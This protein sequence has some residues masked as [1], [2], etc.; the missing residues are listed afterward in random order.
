MSS[1]GPLS[2]P[3]RTFPA[4]EL[5]PYA[6]PVRPDEMKDHRVYFA[7]QYSG[8]SGLVPMLRPLLFV[9]YLDPDDPNLRFF[10]DYDS[11]VAGVRHGSADATD[12]EHAFEVCGPDGGKYIF[13]Y[14]DALHE[15][16]RCALQR[17]ETPDIDMKIRTESRGPKL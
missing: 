5:R 14:E 8:E 6:Q 10:Q 15:L 12:W 3:T 2:W 11:F 9:G 13:E 7:V 16:M 4:T 17:R 1:D